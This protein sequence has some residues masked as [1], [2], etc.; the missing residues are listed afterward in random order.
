VKRKSP[1]KELRKRAPG[2]IPEKRKKKKV[3]NKK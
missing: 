3:R 2:Q 1:E